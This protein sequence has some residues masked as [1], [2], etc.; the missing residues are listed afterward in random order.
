MW[1]R[2]FI[3]AA[4]ALV[5]SACGGQPMSPPASGGQSA[6]P[7]ASVGAIQI[8]DPWVR[9][10]SSM[11]MGEAQ[12]T[13]ASGMAMPTAM[14]MGGVGEAG[15]A[16]S[17]AYMLIRNGGA[18]DRLLKAESGVAGTVELHTVEMK[19]GVMQMRPVE[20]GIDVPANGEVQLKPGGFH[21]MLIGLKQDLKAGDTVALKLQ[22]EK[23]GAVDVTAQ[24]RQP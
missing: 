2:T 1:H 10:A 17:A 21:V 20:G 6:P 15:T 12:P 8:S 9:P 13:P 4:L 11:A 5:L 7:A 14:A 24:V 22:F 19:D 23:A 3:T 16:N 18:A